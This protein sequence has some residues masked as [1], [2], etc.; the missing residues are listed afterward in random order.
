VKGASFFVEKDLSKTLLD[1]AEYLYPKRKQIKPVKGLP[2]HF[3]EDIH[4]AVFGIGGVVMVPL[5]EGS[6]VNEVT[7]Y[8]NLNVAARY[9][10]GLAE[11][12]TEIWYMKTGVS[13]DLGM[14]F[15]WAKDHDAL[16]DPKNLRKTHILLG[17]VKERDPEKLFRAMQARLW[18]P[19]GEARKLLKQ[20]GIDHTS[21]SIG[22][23]IVTGNKVLLVDRGG[24][25]DLKKVQESDAVARLHPEQVHHGV[26][27]EERRGILQ[28]GSKRSFPAGTPKQKTAAESILKKL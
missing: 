11:G 19:H 27:A 20:K 5:A 2:K 28:E 18:S 12:D 15:D 4:P 1:Y 25:V 26:L 8:R 24:F 13:R 21:M 7:E 23:V 9:V 14:G 22:D 10:P 17:K 3:T 6:P 16:P